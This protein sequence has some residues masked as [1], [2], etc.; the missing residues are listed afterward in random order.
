MPYAP[1]K[2]QVLLVSVDRGSRFNAQIVD[3][4]MAQGFLVA[5]NVYDYP[6]SLEWWPLS[7]QIQDH[8][9]CYRLE[10]CFCLDFS[11]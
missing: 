3:G 1:F 11:H 7:M 6:L 9:T 10:G 2:G 5:H 4:K 8:L